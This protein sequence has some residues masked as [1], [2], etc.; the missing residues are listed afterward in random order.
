MFLVLEH[1]LGA[2]E[3]DAVLAVD[4]EAVEVA[5]EDPSHVVLAV[6]TIDLL[7]IGQPHTFVLL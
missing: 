2:V 7:E 5:H 6:P 3:A 4:A 1:S